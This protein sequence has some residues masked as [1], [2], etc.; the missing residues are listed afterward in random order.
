MGSDQNTIFGSDA[1][2]QIKE[3]TEIR[4]PKMY[5]VVLHNDHFTTMEF[6]VEILV[7]IFHKPAQEATQIML[8][9]HR[10]GSGNCGVYSLDIARTKVAQVH[11]LARQHEFPLRCSYEEA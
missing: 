3:E 7:K 11:A 2:L 9:V 8:D 1:E 10:R 5:R 6:V 4:E